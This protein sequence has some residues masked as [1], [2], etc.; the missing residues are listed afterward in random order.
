MCFLQTRRT[1]LIMIFVPRKNIAAILLYHQDTWLDQRC[2]GKFATLSTLAKKALKPEWNV[3]IITMHLNVFI[4]LQ[5]K[6]KNSNQFK[7]SF[8]IGAKHL[9][10]SKQL[11]FCPNSISKTWCN[12]TPLFLESP[13]NLFP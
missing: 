11:D 6:N 9:F 12:L 3:K 10:S 4:E 5:C 13:K 2:A 7:S 8:S 1:N